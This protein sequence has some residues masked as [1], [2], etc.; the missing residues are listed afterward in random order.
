MI[1]TWSCR[2]AFSRTSRAQGDSHVYASRT[3]FV[4][5]SILH[6]FAVGTWLVASAQAAAR[7]P[8]K[9]PRGLE[10]THARDVAVRYNRHT[11]YTRS[12]RITPIHEVADGRRKNFAISACR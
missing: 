3:R 12:R 4:P 8:G 1:Y 7:V 9:R 5:N 11:A 2:I 6:L 10:R